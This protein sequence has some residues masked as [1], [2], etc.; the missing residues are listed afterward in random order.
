M[1][2]KRKKYRKKNT[3]MQSKSNRKRQRQRER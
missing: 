2:Q 3:L 1:R